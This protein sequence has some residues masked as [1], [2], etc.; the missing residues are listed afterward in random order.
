MNNNFVTTDITEYIVALLLA[1]CQHCLP[2]CGPGGF[3]DHQTF[4]YYYYVLV[5]YFVVTKCCPLARWG[6]VGDS[7][8]L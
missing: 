3:S 8:F 1:I 5:F 6:E 4:F 2:C 7:F